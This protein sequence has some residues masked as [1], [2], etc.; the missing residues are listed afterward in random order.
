MSS[1][2]VCFL[3]EIAIS[4]MYGTEHEKKSVANLISYLINDPQNIEK[5]VELAVLIEEIKRREITHMDWNCCFC[6][7]C[8]RFHNCRIKW[9]RGERQMAQYC[10]SYC[11]NFDRCL[12]KF[13]KLEK[14]RRI[15]SEIF[16]ININGNEEEVETARNIINNIT[17]LDCLIK[18][19][20]LA[21]EIRTREL[22]S[23]KWS[24]CAQCNKYNTCRI[25]WHRGENKDPDICCSYCQNYKDCLEKYR[26]QASSETKVIENIFIINIYGDEKEI[27]KADSIVSKAGSPHFQTKLAALAGAV[28]AREAAKFI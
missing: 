4:N 25:K 21:E 7:K 14:S 22:T 28:K 27:K 11:Q 13:Q 3:E 23:M 9:Y 15:V 20:V 10:C 1:N 17:D 12:A 24:C 26:K 6:D 8:E 2:E 19:S 18:L 16:M 5:I